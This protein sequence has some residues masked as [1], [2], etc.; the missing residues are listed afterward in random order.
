MMYRF[1]ETAEVHKVQP[2]FNAESSAV[3]YVTGSLSAP[4][5]SE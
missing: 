1:P 3:V 5:F 2:L 4:S